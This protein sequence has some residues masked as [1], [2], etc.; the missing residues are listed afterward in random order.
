VIEFAVR[1]DVTQEFKKAAEHPANEWHPL[2][3]MVKSALENTG[4]EWAEACFIPNWVGNSKKNPDYRFI[5]IREPLK[6]LD[7]PGMEDQLVFPF[8]TM[9]FKDKRKG[10][11]DA[12]SFTKA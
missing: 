9:N 2:K 6:Q 8:P 7:L 5:A 12:I 10:G 11:L 3:R 1:V 4:Q